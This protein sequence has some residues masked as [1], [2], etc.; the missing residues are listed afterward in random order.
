[1]NS[2]FIDIGEVDSSDKKMSWFKEQSMCWD[3]TKKV[4]SSEN[5]KLDEKSLDLANKF[6]LWVKENS[7][8]LAIWGIN[9]SCCT[10]L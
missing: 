6:A 10:P 4:M 9:S 1:M 2:I 7:H 8:I 3:G 5:A